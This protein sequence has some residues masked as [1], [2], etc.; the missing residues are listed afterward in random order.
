VR[1]GAGIFAAGFL[2]FT[3]LCKVA[4]PILQESERPEEAEHSVAEAA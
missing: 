1:V 4:I 3:L 2:V